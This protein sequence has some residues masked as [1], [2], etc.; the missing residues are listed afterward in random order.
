MNKFSWARDH[1]ARFEQNWTTHTTSVSQVLRCKVLSSSVRSECG[2]ELHHL[3]DPID[4]SE[5]TRFSSPKPQFKFP[6]N[7]HAI[8]A[9]A[10]TEKDT[11]PAPSVVARV[12]ATGNVDLAAM[13][14]A[15]QAAARAHAKLVEH[16]AKPRASRVSKT[17]TVVAPAR[18]LAPL[19]Q[20]ED[21][22]GDAEFIKRTRSIEIHTP[23][24]KALFHA[25]GGSKFLSVG[26]S[27]AQS[28]DMLR[29]EKMVRPVGN[30][31]PYHRA[32]STPTNAKIM[33]PG[34][35]DPRDRQR[36]LQAEEDAKR[37]VSN[38]RWAGITH[39]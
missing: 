38:Q 17:P 1:L 9:M 20:P 32:T 33:V 23:E 31:T 6:V 2:K 19:F 36:Y 37:V 18:V 28:Y 25:N 35:P 4:P 10:Q 21:V 11:T 39:K 13:I 24:A 5:I 27:Y 8:E 15:T 16:E 7:T 12:S 29:K 3:A 34:M 14:A 22:V 26:L 30:A